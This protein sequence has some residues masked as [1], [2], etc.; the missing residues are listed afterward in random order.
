MNLFLT[1]SLC[2]YHQ[3]TIDPSNGI[4]PILKKVLP[5]TFSALCICS[6][7]DSFEN[8]DYYATEL[9]TSFENEGF[10]F[11]SFAVLDSRNVSSA[12]DLINSS[13]MIV[14]MGGHVPTQNTFF[15]R[16]RL[17]ELLNGYEGTIIGIS[18][19]TMNAASTV[20]AQPELDGEAVD[21]SYQRFLPGLGLTEVMILPHYQ[22]Y[23]DI[24]LDH[25]RVY[26]DITYPDSYGRRFYALPDGSY[27]LGIN[28]QQWLC[29]E[30]YLIENGSLKKVLS[31]GE[32]QLLDGTCLKDNPIPII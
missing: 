19:G 16:I 3:P 2:Y 20:Y 1:S 10:A 7:P 25:L 15:S 29:G 21:P 8:A 30:A 14:L 13:D 22:F 6:D 18:A 11:S 24:V 26:E 5:H 32:K 12:C 9:K 17:K 28:G 31:L 27:L 4:I 23:R